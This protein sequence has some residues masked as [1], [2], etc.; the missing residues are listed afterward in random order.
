MARKRWAKPQQTARHD[1]LELSRSYLK[2]LC[3]WHH[4]QGAGVTKLLHP[5][6]ARGSEYSRLRARV[7]FGTRTSTKRLAASPNALFA[8]FLTFDSSWFMTIQDH[9]TA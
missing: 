7:G 2:P 1:R 4:G 9:E 5:H 6:F 8:R 3:K